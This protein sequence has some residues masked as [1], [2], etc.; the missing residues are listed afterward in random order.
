MP[1]S[2]V[3][4]DGRTQ[5]ESSAPD[6]LMKFLRLSST[7]APIATRWFAFAALA[8]SF[9]ILSPIAFHSKFT[10]IFYRFD[11]I[12]LLIA[13]VMQKNVVGERL[14]LHQQ[15]AARHRRI[16][17]AAARFDRSWPVAGGALAGLDW[18]DRCDDVFTPPCLRQPYV[19]CR[20]A[21]GWLRCRPF[22]RRSWG[23][24]RERLRR[25]TRSHSCARDAERA[26]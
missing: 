16:G 23:R 10:L 3:D 19:G 25:S 11:G 17:A 4:I 21:C 12:Y 18:A 24:H 5:T 22:S 20:S 2:P 8:L 6:M 7:S 14:V 1:S 26:C 13:A 15:S 9:L